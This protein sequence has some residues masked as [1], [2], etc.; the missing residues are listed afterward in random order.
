LP[1]LD[2]T[3][4]GWAVTIGSVAGLLA[5]D[6]I[7]S[8]RRPQ[9]VGQREA[10]LW[11]LFYV[12]VAIGFGVTARARRRARDLDRPVVIWSSSRSPRPRA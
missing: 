1:D 5:V 4:A 3:A 10:A 9:A 7:R 11:S 12:A 8:V 2:A 6:P